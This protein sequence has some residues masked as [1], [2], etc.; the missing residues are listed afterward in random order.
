[1]Y[2]TLL[3]ILC[4]LACAPPVVAQTPAPPRRE[5]SFYEQV[6]T[7]IRTESEVGPG[8]ARQRF[9]VDAWLAGV[10]ARVREQRA[11]PTPEYQTRPWLS[12]SPVVD[13]PARPIPTL[14]DSPSVEYG[15]AVS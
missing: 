14:S 4:L 2:K 10:L 7:K 1:M 11:V 6:M 5:P 12:W 9:D 15:G 13:Q 3:L 8:G